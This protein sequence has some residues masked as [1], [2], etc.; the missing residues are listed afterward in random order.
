MLTDDVLSFFVLPLDFSCTILN[1]NRLMTNVYYIKLGVNPLEGINDNIGI[2]FQRI[3]Y[4]TEFFLQG[5]IFLEKSSNIA[6]ELD[7]LDN[8]LVC[9]P[10]DTYD[11][12]VGSVLL[13]KFQ[14]ITANYFDIQYMSIASLV[15]DHVQFNIISPYDSNLELEGDYWWNQD[16]V[17]TGSK[18]T[19]TWDELNLTEIPKFKP[20]VIKGGLSEN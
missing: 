17:Y 6:K 18:E 2:G 16:N 13:A 7:N 12:Y 5:S 14:S 15:G 19:I 10:C 3:K 4:L 11:V 20:T 8:N 1:D 9:L